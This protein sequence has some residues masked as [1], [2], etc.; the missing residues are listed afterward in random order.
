[1]NHFRKLLLVT[2]GAIALCGAQACSSGTELNPQPLPPSEP[3]RDPADQKG[4]SGDNGG[5]S[6]TAPETGADAGAE[7][8]DAADGG[9]R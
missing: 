4:S 6:G 2:A 8:G 3:A 9:D 5:T 1:M 7:G